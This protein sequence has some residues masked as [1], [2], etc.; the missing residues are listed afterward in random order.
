MKKLIFILLQTFIFYQAHAG[1]NTPTNFHQDKRPGQ[2]NFNMETIENGKSTNVDLKICLVAGGMID[3]APG[4]FE[5]GC[6]GK[7]LTDTSTELAYLVECTGMP[8]LNITWK[9][10]SETDFLNISKLGQMVIVSKYRYVGT[11][12]DSDAIRK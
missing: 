7:K 9:R 12:C 4:K 8:P 1:E 5:P 11:H 2:Y 10:L 3:R 6:T